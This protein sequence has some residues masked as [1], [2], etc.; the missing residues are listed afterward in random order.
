MAFKDLLVIVDNDP[1]CPSRIDVARA[2][3]ERHEAHLT[4]LHV[5][6]RPVPLYSDVPVPAS[7][8]TMQRRELEQAAE[9]AKS[10][11]QDR[12][13][14]PTART[15]WRVGEGHPLDVVPADARCAD[16]TILGQGREL[17]EASADLSGLPADLVL[18]V[19]RPV[20]VV[21]RYG[22]FATV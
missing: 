22:A 3:A 16:L 14:G 2:L 13:R 9:R 7:L 1:A 15:D 19:G 18:A 11:F 6:P 20:L 4:G 8:E 12:T 10:L 17:G 5:M 21:P